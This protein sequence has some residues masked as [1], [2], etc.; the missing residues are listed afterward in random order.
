V[1][2]R[3]RQLFSWGVGDVRGVKLGAEGLAKGDDAGD[4][5]S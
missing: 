5:M 4:D 3:K 1:K 2:A